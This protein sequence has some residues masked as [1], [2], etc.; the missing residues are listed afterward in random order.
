MSALTDTLMDNLRVR[1]PGA[2]DGVI[3]QEAFFV[4]DEFCRHAYI[5]RDVVEIPLQLG[6]SLYPVNA[7]G[8][9]AAVFYMEHLTLDLSKALFDSDQKLASLGVLPSAADL[10]TPVFVYL[11]L[12]PRPTAPLT[13]DGLLPEHLW[14]HWSDVIKDGVLGRMMGQPAKPYSN[15]ALAA[16]HLR[17][18]RS[19][20]AT[21]RHLTNTGHVPG[22]QRWSFPKWA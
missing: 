14:R 10:A 6:S 11:A 19:G 2:L 9:I 18:F 5:W 12:A 21:A 8:E 22:A 17:R 7:P 20:M 16:H 15:V 13:L 3:L 1:L 4:V